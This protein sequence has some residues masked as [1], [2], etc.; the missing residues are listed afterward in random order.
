MRDHVAR[1]SQ[2]FPR[3][4]DGRFAE[5]ADQAGGQCQQ[6]ARLIDVRD[7]IDDNLNA[8]AQLEDAYGNPTTGTLAGVTVALQS[9]GT[10]NATLPA[11]LSFVNGQA[12]IP[13]NVRTASTAACVRVSRRAETPK[14]TL[15]AASIPQAPDPR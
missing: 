7:E 1:C 12:Q 11:A 2:N 3:I 6:R 5:P 8:L 14:Y 9:S 10:V 4:V 15:A 13:F